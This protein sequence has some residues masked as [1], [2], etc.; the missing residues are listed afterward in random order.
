MSGMTATSSRR[1]T[2][3]LVLVALLFCALAP[4]ASQAVRVLL[5]APSVPW[6]D[7]CASP[8]FRPPTA[9]GRPGGSDGAPEP[10]RLHSTPMCALC[11]TGPAPCALT[12]QPLAFALVPLLGLLRAPDLAPAP[13]HPTSPPATV[14]PRAPPFG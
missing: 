4:S 2:S 5:A 1:A 9:Q 6:D 8:G 10:E 13:L 11:A 12:S 14:H 7:M 3:W